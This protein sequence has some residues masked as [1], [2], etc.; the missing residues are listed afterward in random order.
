M[1]TAAGLEPG[2]L[3]GP[4]QLKPSY[5]SVKGS[6]QLPQGLP[7]RNAADCRHI[8]P[9]DITQVLSAAGA[10]LPP[11]TRPREVPCPAAPH[12]T[13]NTETTAWI[14]VLKRKLKYYKNERDELTV[15][16]SIFD[17]TDVWES[18]QTPQC[19]AMSKRGKRV[20]AAPLRSNA[21]RPAFSSYFVAGMVYRWRPR[22]SRAVIIK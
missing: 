13:F 11:A 21:A 8:H 1:P 2:D 7:P 12:L 5:D 19:V 15:T 10:A 9:K 17:Y 4:F 18:P 3:K 20:P 22:C 6:S 16:T 14:S